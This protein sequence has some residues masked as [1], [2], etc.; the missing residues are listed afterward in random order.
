VGY[1]FAPEPDEPPPVSLAVS[2][3]QVSLPEPP[4]SLP[5]LVVLAE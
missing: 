2:V 5:A 1:R 4:V 3:P